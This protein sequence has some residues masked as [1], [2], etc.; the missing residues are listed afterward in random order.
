MTC[1][2]CGRNL[3]RRGINA[4]GG[5][6]SQRLQDYIKAAKGQARRPEIQCL[7][8]NKMF[9]PKRVDS[10]VCSEECRNKAQRTLY[11]SSHRKA[12]AKQYG[13]SYEQFEQMIAAGCY[14]P[15]CQQSADL[16][17]D[18][19]HSCC[20]RRGSCGKCVRGALCKR[21]NLYLGLIEKDYGFALWVLKQPNMVMKGE[22]K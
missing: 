18:H 22:W 17:I 7:G 16:Q 11:P 20:P 1:W 10:Q 2:V 9:R 3:R 19:D 4:C 14:A 15:G 21:H 5:F 12:R 6:C 13:L 8:C